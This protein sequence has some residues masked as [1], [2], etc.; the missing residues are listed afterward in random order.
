MK[1][2][3]KKLIDITALIFVFPLLLIYWIGSAVI[4][5]NSLFMSASQLLSLLPGKTGSYIRKSFFSH[6][7]TDCHSNCV[8]GFGSL[9]SQIDTEIGEGVYIGPQCNIGKC[10]IEK[11]CLIGSGVHIL[12]GSSQHCFNDLATP[13]QQ[14]EG[15]FKK[16]TIGEDSWI[17]NGALIM[18]N[19]GKQCIVGT[20]SV[21]T[22]DI[23][24]YSI[25][26]GNP[27]KLISK[28]NSA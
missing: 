8:I 21:V 7:I 13:I 28:R 6:S 26:A 15:Y 9:F 4:E 1:G 5:K 25:V 16:V 22:K 3:A 12:S 18:A 19:I 23:E 24:D 14:Q 20:G 2:I 17:G 11:N 10:K 27:A